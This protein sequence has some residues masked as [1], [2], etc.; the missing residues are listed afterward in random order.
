MGLSTSTKP[1]DKDGQDFEPAFAEYREAMNAQGSAKDLDG[2]RVYKSL[3]KLIQS[4][5]VTTEQI[6]RKVT[7]Q[8]EL[9]LILENQNTPERLLLASIKVDLDDMH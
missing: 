4:R 6:S 5:A 2:V 9:Q 7:I 8:M 3:Q 1:H